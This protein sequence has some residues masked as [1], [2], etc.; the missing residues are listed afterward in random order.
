MGKRLDALFYTFLA[1]FAATA[2]VTLLGVIGIVTIQGA[3]LNALLGAFLLELAGAVVVLFRGAPFFGTMGDVAGSVSDSV[4]VIDQL[5]PEIE[6]VISG[7]AQAEVNRQF[8]VIVRRQGK[9]LV[10][11]QKLQVI[12]GAKLEQLSGEEKDAIKIHA[13]RMASLRDRW[14]KLYEKRLAAMDPRRRSEIDGEL[15]LLGSDMKV[16]FQAILEFLIRQGA[17]LEDHYRNVRS[18]VDRLANA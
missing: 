9:D 5:I 2:I 16:E 14:D 3:Q 10:A 6:A 18:I 8:G 7:K 17:V 1:I 4:E 15:K 12:P 11:Y 13:G